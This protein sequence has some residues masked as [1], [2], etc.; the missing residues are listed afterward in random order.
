MVKDE[1]MVYNRGFPDYTNLTKAEKRTLLLP[2]VETIRE[3]YKDP[4]NQRKFKEWKAERY[5]T[6]SAA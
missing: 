4:E 1:M 3:F 5:K 6:K 2:L